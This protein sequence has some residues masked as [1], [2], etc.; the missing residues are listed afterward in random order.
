MVR[1]KAETLEPVT[2]GHT[3]GHG[4]RDLLWQVYASGTYG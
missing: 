2:M 3:R 4:C 1:R